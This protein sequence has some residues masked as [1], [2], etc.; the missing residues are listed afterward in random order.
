MGVY[1]FL[2]ILKP[3]LLLAGS[4]DEGTDHRAC[5]EW[6]GGGGM[7]ADRFRLAILVLI[8]VVV[9][10]SAW[11]FQWQDEV[12]NELSALARIEAQLSK[13]TGSLPSVNYYAETLNG[14]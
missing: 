3:P 12:T 4:S 5:I 6:G 1:V 13:L 8:V 2:D 14:G 11:E 7:N 9:A 10:A